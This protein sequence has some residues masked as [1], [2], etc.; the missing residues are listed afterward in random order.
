MTRCHNVFNYIKEYELM[1]ENAIKKLIEANERNTAAI[2]KLLVA[3]EANTNITTRLNHKIVE[4]VKK[5]VEEAKAQ[6]EAAEKETP[7]KEAVKKPAPK[8]EAPKKEVVEE[9]VQ[10]PVQQVMEEVENAVTVNVTHKT[11]REIA[12]KAMAEGVCTRDD[13]VKE[14]ETYGAEKLDELDQDGLNGLYAYLTKFE[15]AEI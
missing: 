5:E 4:P 7:K 1:I 3:V 2:E 11:V 10:Q 8:K 12:N 14:I 13:I 6:K 15:T 9:V